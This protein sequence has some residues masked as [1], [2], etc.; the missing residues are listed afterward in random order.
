ME[1][2]YPTGLFSEGFFAGKANESNPN[3]PNSTTGKFR[4]ICSLTTQ[5]LRDLQWEGNYSMSK[6]AVPGMWV[7]SYIKSTSTEPMTCTR[8]DSGYFDCEDCEYEDI[9]VDLCLQRG[10]IRRHPGQLNPT[11]DPNSLSSWGERIRNHPPAPQTRPEV[12][13]QYSGLISG[14]YPADDEDTYPV[15]TPHDLMD[16]KARVDT[17]VAA[18]VIGPP[19]QQLTD[20]EQHMSQLVNE[21]AAWNFVM[22]QAEEYEEEFFFENVEFCLEALDIFIW[23]TEAWSML[24]N[25]FRSGLPEFC[26]PHR[27]LQMYDIAIHVAAKLRPACYG[28]EALSEATKE[29]NDSL[30]WDFHDN[31]PFL[32]VCEYRA[33]VLN[34]LGI[35][36]EAIKQAETLLLWYGGMKLF[37]GSWYI[38][39]KQHEKAKIFLLQNLDEG[40]LTVSDTYNFL[41]LQFMDYRNGTLASD[42][43]ESSLARALK[44]NQHV[45]TFL[46]MPIEEFPDDASRSGSTNGIVWAKSYA[47][48]MLG[49]ILWHSIPGALEWLESMKFRC[50]KVPSEA[51]LIELL[52]REDEYV[53]ILIKPVLGEDNVRELCVTRNPMHMIGTATSDFIWPSELGEGHANGNPILVHV[54][55]FFEETL[56]SNSYKRPSSAESWEHFEYTSLAAVPFWHVRLSCTTAVTSK[57]TPSCGSC[58]ESQTDD[59]K[60]KRCICSKTYYCNSDCQKKEWKRHKKMHQIL[61][62]IKKRKEKNKEEADSNA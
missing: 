27:A 21:S 10:T 55:S 23:S 35:F 17:V 44:A 26:D 18:A 62:T 16:L 49:N 22:E 6:R 31:R 8:I 41:L 36:S 54:S 48:S 7:P 57:P 14:R 34:D 1:R 32:R 60:L 59:H 15:R 2:R 37:L 29:D 28:S 40:S 13:T 43:L 52:E 9:D 30:T 4:H 3:P 24:G 39:N 46:F 5:E 33:F 61:M 53:K 45:P 20:Q 50:G 12:P 56:A 19:P 51:S 58:Y 38:Q 25:C 47:K 42:V 11:E